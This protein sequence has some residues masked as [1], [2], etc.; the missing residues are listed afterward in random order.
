MKKENKS[1][2]TISGKE[3]FI[4]MIA[5]KHPE[6]SKEMLELAWHFHSL[7]KAKRY[8][9]ILGCCNSYADIASKAIREMFVEGDI[10]IQG[11]KHNFY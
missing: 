7:D 2:K 8:S 11:C 4:N 6:A 1:K 9:G 5:A 3:R 10:D